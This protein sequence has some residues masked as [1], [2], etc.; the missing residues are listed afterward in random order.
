MFVFDLHAGDRAV[1]TP[2]TA[3]TANKTRS[4]RCFHNPSD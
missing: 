1:S 2:K 4:E 3:S